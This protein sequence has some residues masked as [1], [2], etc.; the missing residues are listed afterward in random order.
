MF[1]LERTGRFKRDFKKAASQHKD[2]AKLEEVVNMIRSREI[3]PP[4]YKDHQLSGKLHNL[5]ECHIEPD[6]LLIYQVFEQ[7]QA[8]SLVATGDHNSVFMKFLS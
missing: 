8:I 1:Y 3:L 5:R 7:E 6:W 4:K 2:L